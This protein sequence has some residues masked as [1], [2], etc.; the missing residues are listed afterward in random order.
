MQ[1]NRFK[2]LIKESFKSFFLF[3]GLN[4]NRRNSG[5]LAP[6]S[7]FVYQFKPIDIDRFN[8]MKAMNINTVIDVGAH[9]GEFSEQIY[10]ILPNAK[11]YC[12]EPIRKNFIELTSNLNKVL[13]TR[14]AWET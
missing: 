13:C 8:W 14:V 2:S 4:I 9:L 7:T 1:G 3:L 6:K 11:F 5:L 12:F 10:R